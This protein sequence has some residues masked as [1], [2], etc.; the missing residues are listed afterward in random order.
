M[1]RRRACLL[2]VLSCLAVGVVAAQ[3][4]DDPS[5]EPRLAAAVWR[6]DRDFS[7][8]ANGFETAHRK[9]V[10]F[11]GVSRSSEDFLAA[12]EDLTSHLPASVEARARVERKLSMSATTS[13]AGGRRR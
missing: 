9:G 12:L 7:Q 10:P 13:R 5:L 11:A 4:V 6:L 8:W 1:V 3:S 2:A